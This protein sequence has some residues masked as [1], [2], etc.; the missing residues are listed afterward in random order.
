MDEIG[1]PQKDEDELALDELAA[2]LCEVARKS[3]GP[4]FDRKAIWESVRVRLEAAP[5][6]PSQRVRDN[7]P[8][9]V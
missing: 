8:S 7:P 5:P 1:H 6:R 2:R 3:E 4:G 9:A